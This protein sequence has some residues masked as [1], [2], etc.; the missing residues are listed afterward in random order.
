MPIVTLKTGIDCYY[1]ESGA[2]EPVLL[3]SGAGAD[4]KEWVLQVPELSREFRVIAFDNRGIGRSSAPAEKES[5]SIPLLA[6]DTL[7]LMESLGIDRAHI[8]GQS[9][10][11][12][13][14]QEL[15]LRHPARVRSLQLCVTWGRSDARIRNICR[16]MSILI[17][18]GM[19][20]EYIHFNYTLAYSPA[21][22]EAQPLFIDEIYRSMVTENSFASKPHGLLGQW[23]A[24]YHHDALDRLKTLKTPTLVVTGEG[25][26]LVHPEYPAQ[27]AGL[28]PHALFHKFQG[29]CASHLLHIEMAPLYNQLSL[30]FLRAY[31]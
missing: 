13:V 30:D 21:L 1:E 11:S 7:A 27:V 12:A 26:I 10:G 17:E 9:L 18:K 23:R 31:K 5:Y 14:A 19:M 24:V 4:H 25:D 8:I 6:C 20:E 3:I 28:I 2:G 29:K 16:V 22:M 15:A